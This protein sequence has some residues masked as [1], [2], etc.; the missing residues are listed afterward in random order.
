VPGACNPV[1]EGGVKSE[2]GAFVLVV[3]GMEFSKTGPAQPAGPGP[4]GGEQVSVRVAGGA[5]EDIQKKIVEMTP[6]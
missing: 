1:P 4:C 6:S 3:I 5:E 2:V